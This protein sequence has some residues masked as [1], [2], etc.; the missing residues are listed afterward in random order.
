MCFGETL[1]SNDAMIHL[2]RKSGY[3]F[4]PSPGDWKQVRFQKQIDVAPQDIP[5]ETWRVAATDGFV[6]A[7]LAR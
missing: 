2:A 4:A 3:R 5:C 7:P 1:R 6:A